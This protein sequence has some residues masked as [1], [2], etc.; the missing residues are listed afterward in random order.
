M[1]NKF[2][3]IFV[4]IFL[5]GVTLFAQTN[6][7]FKD[8]DI[9]AELVKDSLS[10]SDS[11]FA[12]F[13]TPSAIAGLNISQLAL[14]N[15]TQ[16]GDNSLTWTITGNLGYNYRS[17]TWNFFN[18]LKLAYGR[19]KLGTQD[20][21]TND[22]EFYLESVLSVKVGWPVDPF[23]SNTVRTTVAPGYNYNNNQATEIANFFDPGYVTQ[24]LGFTYDRLY[25]FK[26][27]LGVAVQETFTNHF[28]QYSDNI[29]TS[30]KE[31]FKAETGIQSVTSGQIQI[32]ENLLLNSNLTLFT[33]FESLD[34][35][36]V[37]W[38][39]S[40]VAKVNSWL[41]VNIGFL[42]IYQ[43]DQSPTA[44]MKQSLQLGI[45]YSIL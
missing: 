32:A 29:N 4:A 30:K 2:M 45:V 5:P 31:A 16:G 6:S 14:S 40:I 33:R 44:Q 26:T 15:W 39:N 24:S 18:N 23:F 1:K 12:P 42:F 28:R 34:V 36:D 20:F 11:V 13:W 27:R 35:W 17:M 7:I 22:N 41:N 8:N 38:D 21:R 10:Q 37:R 9:A 43:K 3:F 25:N 19:T